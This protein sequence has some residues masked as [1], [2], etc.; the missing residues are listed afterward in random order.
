[1]TRSASDEERGNLRV[2]PRALPGHHLH[3][4]DQV[5]SHWSRAGILSSDWLLQEADPVLLLQPDRA[6]PADCLHGGA[7]LHAAAGLGGETL[8]G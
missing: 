8:P 7:R 4:Q 5:S 6:L 1:M 3:H 2:L